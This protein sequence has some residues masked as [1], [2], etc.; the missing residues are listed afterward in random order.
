MI[1]VRTNHI[2]LR[3]GRH[4]RDGSLKPCVL[5]KPE[6]EKKWGPALVQRNRR[7]QNDRVPVVENA[8]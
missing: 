2:C 5:A 8:M 1:L 7:R 3:V 6:K 4:S